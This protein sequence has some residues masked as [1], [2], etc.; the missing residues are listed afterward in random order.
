MNDN[1]SA[2][3]INE[4]S[5][6]VQ[7]HLGIRQ[8]VIQR[9]AG[10]ST[11]CKSWCITIVSAILVII[12]DK[13]K[14]DFALIAIIPTFLFLILDAY[15]LGLEKAF[16]TTYNDFVKKLH[17]GNAVADDLY[18]VV[19]NGSETRHQIDAL[20]SLSVWG[21]YGLLALLIVVARLLILK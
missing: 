16:R 5:P 9:M 3:I 6:S 8:S 2:V 13:R 7:T 10:N 20:K 18:A 4:T 15:Y 11:S 17:S 12:A 14:P 1:Q 21:F 19:P